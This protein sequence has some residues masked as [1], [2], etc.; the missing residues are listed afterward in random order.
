MS[1]IVMPRAARKGRG[2]KAE[3]ELEISSLSGRVLPIVVSPI[4]ISNG[5]GNKLFRRDVIEGGHEYA[6][7]ISTHVVRAAAFMRAYAACGAVILL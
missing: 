4:E 3:I 5:C 7:E 6:D 2:T 1:A